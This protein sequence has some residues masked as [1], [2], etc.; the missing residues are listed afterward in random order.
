MRVRSGN[1]TVVPLK[2]LESKLLERLNTLLAH[3]L[4]LEGEDLLGGLG[5]V[6]TVC[7]YGDEDTA[8]DL[9]EEMGV[10][11]D[12]TGFVYVSH[13]GDLRERGI[14][15]RFT[16]I[17]LGNVGEDAVDHA[18]EHPV[19]ERVTGIFDNRDDVCPLCRQTDQITSTAVTEL[20]SVHHTS[21]SDNVGNVTDTRTRGSAEVQNFGAGAHEDCFETTEDTCG[22]LAAEGVPHTV[23]GFCGGWGAGVGVVG[24]EGS[25]DGKTLFAVGGFTGDQVPIH[26]NMCSF[27]RFRCERG[28]G[29]T[30]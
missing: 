11:T 2:G 25:V 19:F 6:D 26:V 13:L 24:C 14:G 18:D 27:L 1:D 22:K 29:C 21:R 4:H 9:E 8:A 10:Q 16:L 7:L 20:H 28:G 5:A 17:G 15:S 3:L 12:D 30:L 23:F